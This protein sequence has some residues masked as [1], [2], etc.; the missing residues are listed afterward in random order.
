M[1]QANPCITMT[2]E[3]DVQG[4]MKNP[5]VAIFNREYG[6]LLKSGTLSQ[7]PWSWSFYHVSKDFQCHSGSTDEEDE[8][9]VTRGAKLNCK[10][11]QKAFYSDR[12]QTMRQFYNI[13]LIKDVALD[14]DR[15][16]HGHFTAF[17]AFLLERY[18]AV[19]LECVQSKWLHE[20][21]EQ[22]ALWLDQKY[23]NF[24]L[25]RPAGFSVRHFKLFDAR[26]ACTVCDCLIRE[27]TRSLFCLETQQA[28]CNEM[29]YASRT[30]TAQ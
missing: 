26:E 29:C 22:S 21:L 4:V 19:L 17:V 16:R 6:R 2:A 12:Q 28:F 5:F 9:I 3:P 25:L 7:N 1:H 18:E 13:M 11:L 15:A 30:K 23:G 27:D 14:K 20:R 24:L 8:P 10:Y